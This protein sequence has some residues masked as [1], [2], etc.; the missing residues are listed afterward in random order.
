M[1]KFLILGIILLISQAVIAQV[2]NSG[3]ERLERR[4][5]NS[6]YNNDTDIQRIERLEQKLFGAEQSGNINDRYIVLR[7]AS[8]NYKGFTP[9]PYYN[10]AYY[11][12]QT[13]CGRYP[14]YQP[15][16][17]TY[18]QGSSWKR[19]MWNN[20]RNFTGFDAGVPTG[21]TPAM[22]P[23]YMD[24]FEADRALKKQYAQ[25]NHG[26]RYSNTGSNSGIGV[27]LID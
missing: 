5:F 7:N 9:Y 17:F 4:I 20:F 11:D 15:P 2:T 21:F 16:L 3:L 27:N 24:W 13:Y 22:D 23:A 26:Y 14:T 18:G 12:G 1:K 8:R 6:T 25:N 10:G 19:T